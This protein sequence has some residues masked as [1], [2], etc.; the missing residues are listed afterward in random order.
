MNISDLLAATTSACRWSAQ[1][2]AGTPALAGTRIRRLSAI[3]W[4]FPA[5]IFLGC[6]PKQWGVYVKPALYSLPGLERI[7]RQFTG[8]SRGTVPNFDALLRRLGIS[9]RVTSE[10]LRR[11]PLHGAALRVVNHPFGLLEGIVFGALLPQVR[12]DF[13]IVANSILGGFGT[14]SC[15]SMP[16]RAGA[17]WP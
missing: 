16:F 15:S 17:R 4:A 9:H 3:P 11:I 10:D 12:P 7:G 2:A 14:G 13:K 5:S 1:S 6:F 8:T